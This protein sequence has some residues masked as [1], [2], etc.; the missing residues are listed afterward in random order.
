[1]EVGGGGGGGG[2]GAGFEGAANEQ[3]I[4]WRSFSKAGITGGEG[5]DRSLRIYKRMMAVR[6]RPTSMTVGSGKNRG[7]I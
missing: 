6:M 7:G 5:S 3:I 2:G 4:D 1:M